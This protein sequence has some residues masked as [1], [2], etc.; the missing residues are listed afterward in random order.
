MYG[1]IMTVSRLRMAQ[2]GKGVSTLVTFYGCPLHCDFCANPFCRSRKTSYA[3]YTPQRLLDLL[4]KDDIY[5]KM[6]GGGIV[7]GGGEP[8]LQA[9]YIR[10]VCCLADPM[11]QKRIETSL[12]S[13]WESIRLLIDYIDEWIV[14]IKDM[15][16]EIYKQYTGKSN[17]TVLRNLKLLLQNV[18]TE[19]IW[20]RVPLIP[21]Y[22]NADDVKKSA[23]LLK[24]MGFAR[25]EEFEYRV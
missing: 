5:Y 21:G 9:E 12:Y 13:K 6:T 17:R 23:A 10:T 3:L 24:K 22:N 7:F 16:T 8:L 19:K 20:I 25:I 15:N 11:W 2:D 4:R 1:Q 14:D 18:P